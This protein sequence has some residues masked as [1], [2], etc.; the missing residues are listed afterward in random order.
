MGTRAVATAVFLVVICLTAGCDTG[1]PRT[2]ERDEP[3]PTAAERFAQRPA[4]DVVKA[5][6][7]AMRSLRSLHV[8][9][10]SFVDGRRE[11]IMVSLS[12]RGECDATLIRDGAITKVRHHDGIAYFQPANAAAYSDFFG[13]GWER[14]SEFVGGRW[15]MEDLGVTKAVCG[16]ERLIDAMFEGEVEGAV[17]PSSASR[18]DRRFSSSVPRSRTTS[19]AP[20]ATAAT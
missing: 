15:L 1:E 11:Q 16:F 17:S 4:E 5:A 7:S 18:L 6:E 8:E 10:G 19:C 9:Q 20:R 12:K 13:D 3:P 2:E 14:I